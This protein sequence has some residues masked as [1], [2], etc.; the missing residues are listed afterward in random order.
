MLVVSVGLGSFVLFAMWA[1]DEIT[2]STPSTAPLLGLQTVSCLADSEGRLGTTD[3][4]PD[5]DLVD[6]AENVDAASTVAINEIPAGA[7][8]VEPGANIQAI[9]ESQPAGSTFYLLAGVYRSQSI[10]PRK[11]DVYIGQP[12]AILSGEDQ[13]EHAFKGHAPNVTICG[14]VIE[15]YANPAQ[16]GAIN[17]GGSD[18]AIIGNEVRHNW[19][20]GITINDGF[21]VIANSIH[22][23]FQIG[24]KGGGEGILIEGNEIAF[25]NHRDEYS[26]SWESGGSKFLRTTDLVVRGN[27]VHDNHGHGLWTD[28]DN[29][30]TLYENNVVVNN[31]G[32]GIFHEIS[33]DAVIRNNRLEGNALVHASGGIRITSSPNVE[34][35]GN[36]LIGNN[37]GIHA[38]QTD[39]GGGSYGVFEIRNLWVHDNS[40]EFTHGWSGLS[41]D[42]SDAYYFDKNNRF[43]RNRYSLQG[44]SSPFLWMNTELSRE[45]W[46]S[47]GLDT[48]GSVD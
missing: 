47:Y 12:G 1:G 18:W 21:Q 20:A 24:I 2:A 8:I 32:S 43:D 48:T 22:H 41:V 19:G 4:P 23:N 40:I 31:Y 28:Y 13:I 37:G 27:Y 42:G 6:R 26:M 25:N 46:T 10:E 30:D 16:L 45:E 38:S 36:S 44:V 34:V 14:F 7:I 11:G 17:G 5:E 39:R 9:A 15:K 3:Q 35:Y 33:Y 29:I